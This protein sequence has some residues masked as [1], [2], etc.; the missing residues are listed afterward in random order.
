[1]KLAANLGLL[2]LTLIGI[3]W[4]LQGAS[5]VGGSVMSGQAFWL[6]AGVVVTIAGLASLVW[7]NARPSA[8]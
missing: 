1:M 8:R 4:T 3:L 5:I 7:F 6:C 2:L